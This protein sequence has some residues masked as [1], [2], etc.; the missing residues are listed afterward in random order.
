VE[1]QRYFDEVAVGDALPTLR[2]G[3]LSIVHTVRWAAFTENW[4]RLHYDREFVAGAEGEGR[5]IASG[6]F[7]QALVCRL[8]TDWLG[9]RGRLHR[10]TIRQLA[11]TREGDLFV[12]QGRVAARHVAAAAG[13]PVRHAGIAGAS[14]LAAERTPKTTGEACAILATMLLPE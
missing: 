8:L 10:L 4:Y 12:G 14:P 3:P 2:F 9:P 6:G 11:P 5:F 13:A 7:R 1:A